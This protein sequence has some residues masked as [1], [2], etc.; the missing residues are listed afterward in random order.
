MPHKNCRDIIGRKFGDYLVISYAYSRPQKPKGKRAFWN[1]I[2]KCG[3]KA[4]VSGTRLRNGEATKCI[5]CRLKAVIN[6][7][8][9]HGF[10]KDGRYGLHNTKLDKIKRSFYHAWDSMK[11]RC[12]N[13]NHM[14]YTNYG[15]RGIMVCKRWLDFNNFKEDMWVEFYTR[16]NSGEKI[17]LDRIDVNGNYEPLNCRWATD[18]KQ[19]R[20]KR[21]S[22]QTQ[23]LRLHR[24]WVKRLGSLVTHVI[25]GHTKNSTVFFKYIGISIPEFRQYIESQFEPWMNWDNYGTYNSKKQTWQIG[26]YIPC[27]K[28]DL[29]QK[30]QRQKCYNYKNLFPQESLENISWTMGEIK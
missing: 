26:H 10:V 2:C 16:K 8:T 19:N 18:K 20:N 11:S 27:F 12:L 1:V 5:N 22:S 13:A 7:N 30:E 23:N 28:F 9:K 24:K 21:N 25:K 3:T 14:Q 4:V 6:A 17:S 29:T 15:G